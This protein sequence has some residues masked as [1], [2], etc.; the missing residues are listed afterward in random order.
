MGTSEYD[1]ADRKSDRP[2][3]PRAAPAPP[4]HGPRHRRMDQRPQAG[5]PADAGTGP[6]PTV[7]GTALAR[8]NADTMVGRPP[9]CTRRSTAYGTP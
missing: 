6:A 8:R 5:P 4:A 7:E 3:C 1:P 2:G 9:G